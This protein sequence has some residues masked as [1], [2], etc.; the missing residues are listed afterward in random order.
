MNNIYA[1]A[2]INHGLAGVMAH[3]RPPGRIAQPRKDAMSPAFALL[4]EALRHRDGPRALRR[5][6][7]STSGGRRRDAEFLAQMAEAVRVEV[8]AILIERTQRQ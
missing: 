7:P 1:S 3:A 4:A 2:P 6:S 8:A 5:A